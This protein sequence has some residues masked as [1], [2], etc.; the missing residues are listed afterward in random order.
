MIIYNANVEYTKIDKVCNT[1]DVLP[2]VLNLF[3]LTYDS[4]LMAG[5]DIFSNSEGIV[6]FADYSW[7]TNKGC[8]SYNSGVFISD[9]NDNKKEDYIKR[10]NNIVSNRYIMSRNILI[11]DYYRLIYK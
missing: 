4:R 3:G 2:T 5:R 6:I 8:Y 7:L 11:Y 9:M 10:I 1:I